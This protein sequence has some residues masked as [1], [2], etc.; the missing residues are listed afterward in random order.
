M[1]LFSPPNLVN[2]LV[3]S[4]L[5][6]F[7]Y[8]LPFACVKKKKF[9]VFQLS[10]VVSDAESAFDPSDYF[11]QGKETACVR[12]AKENGSL[13]QKENLEGNSLSKVEHLTG[14]ELQELEDTSVQEG[15]QRTWSP[16][17]DS[18]R[19]STA[20]RR[21]SSSSANSFEKWKITRNSLPGSSTLEEVFSPQLLEPFRRRSSNSGEK[22]VR[23]SMRLHK[24]TEH[25]GLAWFPVP[26]DS[27][28]KSPLPTP[29]CKSRTMLGESE[30]VHCRGKNLIQ[31]SALGKENTGSIHPAAGSCRRCSRRRSCVS[32][33]QE[34]TRSQTPKRSITHSVCRKDRSNRELYEEV[35]IPL[36]SNCDVSEVSATSDVLK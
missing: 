9:F 29:A 28:E 4:C 3:V 35:A 11:Q 6:P 26:S 1:L 27:H 31:F 2:Y 5:K 14:L 15:A 23:R 17:K 20:R 12:E 30:N 34:T 7:L 13:R 18:V 16:Q 22:M 25:E 24:D 32:T 33:N 19:D 36:E 8:G 10:N 21:R